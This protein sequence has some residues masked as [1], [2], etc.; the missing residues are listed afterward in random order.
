VDARIR[1]RLHPLLLRQ[2]RPWAERVPAL[3]D[4]ERHAYLTAIAAMMDDRKQRLGHF[5]AEHA[6]PWA[7]TALGPVPADPPALAGWQK[8]A[9]SIGAYREMYGY[10]HP[11]DPIGPE[12]AS[13]S[14]DMR[15][16]WHE[17]FLA[18]ASADK[19]EVCGMPDG[20]LWLIRDTYAAE[21]KWAPRHV[22]RE[23]R[24]V[25]LGARNAE[26]EQIHAEAGAE[27]ARKQDDHQRA[28]AHDFWA[29]SYQAMANRYRQQEETFA[30][31]MQN[32]H[33]WEQATAASRRR[34][35]AVDAELRGRHP[36]QRIEPL[37]SAEPAPT[38]A[39]ERDELALASGGQIGEMAQWIQDLAVQRKAFREKIQRRQ[40]LMI[41]SEEPDRENLGPTFPPQTMPGRDAILQPPRPRIV[42]SAKI[43][44]AA[45]EPDAGP[46]AAS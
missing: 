33:E 31:A 23:L 43:L 39:T 14:P 3:A 37:R 12:P 17:A 26:Q 16:A 7:V 32:R 20:R 30:H 9:S 45:Q 11:A 2:Q 34:A 1:Q 21:I 22:G 27:V 36:D 8:K 41:P 13:N 25:R 28:A 44:Q 24:L 42:P 29:A 19:P 5:A 15:A 38:S 46:E 6:L 10:N 4:P 35:I 40:A 18:L